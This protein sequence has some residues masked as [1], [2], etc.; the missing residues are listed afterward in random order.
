MVVSGVLSGVMVA[1]LF[2][3]VGV[4]Q[5][6]EGL[7]LEGLV[8][9]ECGSPSAQGGLRQF[10]V[11]FFLLVLVFLLLDLEIV[12]I[13]LMPSSVISWSM[14]FGVSVCLTLVLYALATF[15]EWVEGSLSWSG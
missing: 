7:Y 8:P 6:R 3:V 4:V 12:Y 11:R 9:F 13:L 15:Y 14:A 10:S 5:E 1:L 2:I